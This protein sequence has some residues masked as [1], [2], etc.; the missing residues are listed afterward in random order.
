[1]MMSDSELN[2]TEL[3]ILNGWNGGFYLKCVFTTIF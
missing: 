2:A 3:C 1:M